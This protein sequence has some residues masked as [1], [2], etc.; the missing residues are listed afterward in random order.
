MQHRGE[1]FGAGEGLSRGGSVLSRVGCW[2][3]LQ[4]LPEFAGEGGGVPKVPRSHRLPWVVVG[5][6]FPHPTLAQP[7]P[8]HQPHSL[9]PWV[10][11]GDPDLPEKTAGNEDQEKRSNKLSVILLP[12]RPIKLQRVPQGQL[13]IIIS[14]RA[15]RAM[16]WLSGWRGRLPGLQQQH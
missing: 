2:V 15:P 8:R 6:V 10:W 4:G 14:Q 12:L 1:G 7:H 16:H 3:M 11:D 5:G 9:A 13:Y